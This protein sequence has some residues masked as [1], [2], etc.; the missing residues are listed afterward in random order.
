MPLYSVDRFRRVEICGGIA[1]GKTCLAH[2]LRS[3]GYPTHFENFQ[4]NPFYEAF[5]A[6]PDGNAFETEITFLLQH[7]GQLKQALQGSLPNAYDFALPLDLAYSRVT[8][9]SQDQRVFN[10]VFSSVIEKVR[11]PKVIVRLRCSERVE[12]ERIRQRGRPAECRIALSYLEALETAL[13]DA[14]GSDPFA[15]VPKVELDSEHINF[16]D[17]P[18]G[19]EDAIDAVTSAL[20]RE[21][22]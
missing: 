13:D 3:A 2:V 6:D 17:D 22:A 8:L 19:I 4:H 20:Q 16:V 15:S 7:Y 10:T 9:S 11:L 18:R 12:Q 1:S 5:Y 21:A 14:L